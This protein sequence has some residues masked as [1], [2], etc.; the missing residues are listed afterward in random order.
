MT[1]R[2]GL[3]AR[4]NDARDFTAQREL[5]EA[6]TAHLKLAEVTT[7]PTANPAAIPVPNLELRLP[8]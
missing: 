5:P 6:K 4:F 8:A 1:S 2:P 3:P 7:R